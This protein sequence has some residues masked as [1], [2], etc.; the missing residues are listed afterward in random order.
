M[1]S[2]C[3][4]CG[5]KLAEGVNFCSSCGTRI[6][7][8][9]PSTPVVARKNDVK[10]KDRIAYATRNEIFAFVVSVV[11]IVMMVGGGIL[12]SV[13]RTHSELWGIVSYIE[14][15]YRDVG[16]GLLIF[17]GVSC[18]ISI[19]AAIY[20]DMLRKQLVERLNKN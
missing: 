1:M 17:G 14:K 9:P 8:P 5:V 6:G 19:A 18:A 13:T 10:I 2:Y 20:Y 16:L 15:P 11:G 3:T 4:K 12:G 7:T